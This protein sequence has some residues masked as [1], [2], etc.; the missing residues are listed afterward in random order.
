MNNIWIER[1]GE[2]SKLYYS[3]GMS[4]DAIGGNYGVTRER[5]RQVMSE[6]GLKR[7]KNRCH[8]KKREPFSS[9]SSLED[10]LKNRKG[11]GRETLSALRKF[12]LPTSCEECGKAVNLHIH[13]LKYPAE[14]RE[15]LQILCAS[16][17]H[18]KHRKGIDHNQQ[19]DIFIRRQQGWT[20]KKLAEYY[21]INVSLVYKIIDKVKFN[22]SRLR[23]AG[24]VL[25]VYS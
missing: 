7:I 20:H 21:G 15:D 4:M 17:H 9:F 24:D 25:P 2:I 18:A 22:R 11:E 3:K 14:N 16:C 19:I 13:H 23:R 10:Y 5:M 12:L 1:K 8:W 6:L